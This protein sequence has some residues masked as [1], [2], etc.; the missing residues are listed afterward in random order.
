L[1]CPSL[2]KALYVFEKWHNTDPLKEDLVCSNIKA[3]VFVQIFCGFPLSCKPRAPFAS[4]ALLLWLSRLSKERI[5]QL[6][7]NFAYFS[8]ET[9]LFEF[10][11]KIEKRI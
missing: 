2:A 5:P 10:V 1:V 6:K 11:G 8:L 9:W 7:E 3:S 4:A